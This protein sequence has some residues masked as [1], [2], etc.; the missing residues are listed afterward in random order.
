MVESLDHNPWEWAVPVVHLFRLK[1]ENRGELPTTAFFYFKPGSDPLG[2][3]TRE[4]EE[5]MQIDGLDFTTQAATT[6]TFMMLEDE[7]FKAGPD[8]VM[9]VGEGWDF[10]EDEEAMQQAKLGEDVQPKVVKSCVYCT[11]ET[12]SAYYMSTAEVLE[13]KHGYKTFI[14]QSLFKFEEISN[15]QLNGRYARVLPFNKLSH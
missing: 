11:I 5:I 8:M 4:H 14:P 12:P 6:L 15:E 7:A 9:I 13:D 10:S 3:T 1:F 2:M